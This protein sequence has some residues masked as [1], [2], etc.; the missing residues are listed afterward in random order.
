MASMMQK[1]AQQIT[2]LID[3]ILGLSLI[4]TSNEVIKDDVVN[5]N[6][7]LEAVVRN[8]RDSTPPQVT[9]SIDSELQPEFTFKTNE[10]MLRRIINALTDNALKNTEQGS[11]TLKAKTVAQTLILAVEDTGCGVPADQAEN[12]F[13]RFVKLDSFKQGIGLGLSLSRKLAEQ[14]G[15]IVTLDTSYSPGARFVVTLPIESSE[16]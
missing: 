13:E 15:G 7:L 14:L 16:E 9:L 3:E 10:N 2:S 4:E 1:S 12:I 11:V 5:V 8:F 6:N